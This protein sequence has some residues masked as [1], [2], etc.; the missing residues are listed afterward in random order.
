MKLISAPMQGHTE[1]I[2]RS[3]H[4][5]IYGR[6]HGLAAEYYSPFCRMDHGSARARDLRD[7]S[8][9]DTAQVICRNAEEFDLLVSEVYRKGNRRIDLNLGCP[10]PI[11][12]KKG[13]G[14]A[15]VSNPDDVLWAI[16]RHMHGRPDVTWSVKM[17]LGRSTPDEWMLAID[18]LNEMP[19]KYITMHPRT[20]NQGYKGDLDIAQFE[21]FLS[22]TKHPVVYNGD[23]LLASDISETK[24]RW[25]ELYGIMIGRGLMA[26]P[27]LIAEFKSGVEWS[28]DKRMHH[29]LKLHGAIMA[30]YSDILCGDTQILMKIKPFWEY[31]ENEIGRNQWKLIRKTGNMRNYLALVEALAYNSHNGSH[32]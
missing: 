15:M 18:A 1:K 21:K 20:A 8:P 4:R 14:A 23:V 31:L 17:R 5:D 28:S 22:L 13:R 32:W 2:W 3:S 29:I 24:S 9:F 16:A 30:H 12:L 19:L 27:S 26:R 25:P 10:F 11:Q 7:L 6:D